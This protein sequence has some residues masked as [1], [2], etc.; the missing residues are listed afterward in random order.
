M[1]D[2]LGMNRTGVG[3][4]PFDAPDITKTA[5][6][7]APEVLGSAAGMAELR[8]SYARNADR[9]GSVPPP[10]TVKGAARAAINLLRGKNTAGLIDR[11]SQRLAFERTGTR[12]YDALLVKVETQDAWV[13]GPDI[14]TVR[15]FRAEEHQHAEMLAGAML[16][17]GADPT[18]Q[19]PL[20]DV[21]GVVS[22]GV[23]QALVDP[24]TSLAQ[25]LDA[26]LVAELA[27]QAGWELLIEISATFGLSELGQSC[28]AAQ[29]QEAEHL[30]TVK[31]WLSHHL[32]QE[33][34]SSPEPLT[35]SLPH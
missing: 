5:Q 12:L 26:L 14:A 28:L 30:S 11:L 25:A 32:Q 4:S 34:Q 15:R 20:A 31:G 33:S 8:E 22:L 6:Q 9:L 23:V 13:G 10:T 7:A 17:I 35:T 1:S 16:D 3:M 27:D 2:L 19:T 21:S 29:L 24:R 18:A